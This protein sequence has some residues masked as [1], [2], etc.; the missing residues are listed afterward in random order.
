MHCPQFC[1]GCG[2]SLVK[3]AEILGEEIAIQSS[4]PAHEAARLRERQQ[5]FEK[6]AGIAGLATFGLILITLIVVVFSQIIL[7]GGLLIIPGVLL[8]LLAAGAGAMGIF[9]AYSKS[10]KA[11]L[12][13]RPL[14][15]STEPLAIGAPA[16][17]PLPLRSVSEGTTELLEMKKS[18]E[19]GPIDS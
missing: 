10:L 14:P 4:S 13:E 1:R 5:K 19:T 18:P 16:P 2:L 15:D 9:Q 8:I 17:Y 6:W 11:K 12:G 3:V 7:K